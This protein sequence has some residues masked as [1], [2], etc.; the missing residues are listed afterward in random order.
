MRVLEG[1]TGVGV[2]RARLPLLWDDIGTLELLAGRVRTVL[3][4]LLEQTVRAVRQA[5]EG[6]AFDRFVAQTVPFVGK[7]AETADLMLAVVEA[8]KKFFLET[9][10]GKRTTVAMFSFMQAEFAAA[11]AMWWWNPVGAATH[12]AQTRTIIQVV[13]RSA[14]VRSAASSTAM[15]MLTM[16]G[17]AL[18][19]EV[20]MMTDGLQSGVNW[21]AVGKQAAYAGAVAFLSTA[22]GPALGKAAGA[23]AAA[24][25]KLG[26]SDSTKM[27][28]TDLLTRPVLETGTE[29]IFG[30][31]ASLMVDGYWDPGNLGAD[32]L[33]GAI[34][35]AGGSAASG[36]GLV[37]SRAMNGPRVQMPR[38]DF[39]PDGRPVM[40]VG[41][42]PVGGDTFTG[43]RTGADD[44]KAV[45]AGGQA[46]PS[47]PPPLPL[48][49]LNLPA[50]SLDLPAP[51][52]DLSVPSWSVPSLSVPVAPVP[53]WVAAAGGPVVER[54]YR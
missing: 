10:T 5:G 24:V 14:L 51:R 35:G 39:T 38:L 2:S 4:P 49:G 31:G 7:M 48:P 52:L 26:L 16:P 28:L 43:Y 29:G 50:P 6:E 25:S 3:G 8:E 11:A 9:E 34:S 27:L 13:L 44:P 20:S 23:V 22:G 1:F 45:G 36:L 18:L 53:A 37:V 17:S 12:V 32:L 19:A 47:T 21:S 41:P 46:P 42:T 40:P 30:I 15:Q 33:S 54:W